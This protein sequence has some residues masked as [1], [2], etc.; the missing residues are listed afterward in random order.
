[1]ARLALELGEQA[2]KP[3]AEAGAGAQ[4]QRAGAAHGCAGARHGSEDGPRLG[5]EPLALEG[6]RDAAGRAVD[7]QDAELALQTPEL[8]ADGGLHDVQPLGGT[9]EVQLLG[10]RDEVLELA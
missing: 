7:E 3:A 8:L 4:P 1:M 6:Q 9:A 5:E 2:G 10:D